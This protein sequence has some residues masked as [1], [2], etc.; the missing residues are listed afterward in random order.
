MSAGG[1]LS[2][3]LGTTADDGEPTAEDPV[4]RESD[5]VAAVCAWVAPTDLRGMAWSDP[6][7]HAQY[8][9]YPALEL[10]QEE[11]ARMSPLLAVS[12][13]DAPALLIVG[14]GDTLVPPEHSERIVAALAAER[15]E[16]RLM[17]IEGAG[18]S[19]DEGQRARALNA[20]ADWFTRTLVDA[21]DRRP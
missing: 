9:R 13:D 5:R 11:A 10:S 8:D 1:H 16:G 3:M 14:D 7:H 19:F 12:R 6:A 18:H 4:L 21:A 17:V 20:T 15:V 2:L